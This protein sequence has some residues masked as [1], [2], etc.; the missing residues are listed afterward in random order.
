MKPTLAKPRTA[1]PTPTFDLALRRKLHPSVEDKTIRYKCKL[2]STTQ[3]SI[4]KSWVSRAAGEEL[5]NHR[6]RRHSGSEMT[7][8]EKLDETGSKEL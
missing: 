5:T 4:R 1:A 6:E 3:H 8:T 7:W 2:P